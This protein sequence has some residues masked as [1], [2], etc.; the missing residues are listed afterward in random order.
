MYRSFLFVLT[1]L[2]VTAAQ[3]QPQPPHDRAFWRAVIAQKYQVPTGQAVLPLAM[4]LSRFVTSTDPEL[5][6][7]FGYEILAKWIHRSGKLSSNDLDAL[8]KAFI[9]FGLTGIGESGTDTVFTRS[10]AILNLK[11]LAAADLTTPFLTQ[12][13]FDDLFVLA[14][15]SLSAEKDLRGYVTEKGWAHATAHGADLMR[16]LARNTKLS[17]AQQGRLVA[18]ISSRARTA[19][20][21]FAWGEDARLAAAL[22]SVANRS[23]ADTGAFDAWFV[24]LR[25]EHQQLWEGNFDTTAYM[26]VRAQVNVLAQFS[27]LVARQNNPAFPVTLRD[28]LHATLAAAN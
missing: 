7:S 18:S 8:R 22:V 9:P 28:G 16:I 14:E 11:E 2:M 6:D 12:A 4:E 24:A 25:A 27:S 10:F 13:S 15:Q 23:N 19:G 5:R 21:V 1:M 17:V 3:A 20:I 26:R